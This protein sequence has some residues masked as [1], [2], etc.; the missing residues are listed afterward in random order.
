MINL[1]P[2]DPVAMRLAVANAYTYADA[3][4]VLDQLNGDE[5]FAERV[6][7]VAQALA[8]SPIVIA[9]WRARFLEALR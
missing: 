7:Q 8:L 5:L 6:L 3:K 9:K 2:T 1:P 4:Q